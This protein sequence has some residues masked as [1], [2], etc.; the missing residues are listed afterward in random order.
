MRAAVGGAVEG[1]PSWQWPR[2]EVQSLIVMDIKIPGGPPGGTGVE[3][4]KDV[5]DVAD[6]GA[7]TSEVGA[8]EAAGSDAIAQVAEQVAKGEIGQQE[9]VDRILVEV[10]DSPMV[11]AAPAEL[12][13]ELG[14]VLRSLLE[15]DPYLK[16]LTAA[17]G[18]SETE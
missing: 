2:F 13:Q 14:E 8:V 18:P 3:D 11:A 5:T 15:T 12:R 9:A 7:E 6:A 1:A 10:L 16:S 4:L 17:I